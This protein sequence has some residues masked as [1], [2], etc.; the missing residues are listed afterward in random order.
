[1]RERRFLP[2][3]GPSKSRRRASWCVITAVSSSPMFTSRR[4]Q[5]RMMHYGIHVVA[6]ATASML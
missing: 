2:S 5:G 6:L 1:M 4:S 3:R